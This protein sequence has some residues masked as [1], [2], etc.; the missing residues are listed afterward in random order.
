MAKKD[1]SKELQLLYFP[2]AKEPALVKVP[3]MS[4]L[5]VDGQGDPNTSKDYMNAIGALYSVAYT[6]KFTLKKSA[7]GKDFTVMPLESLWWADDP[8]D[9]PNGEKRKW[10]WTAMIMVPK[11]V[12]KRVVNDTIAQLKK[13][14]KDKELPGLP[15]L[16]LEEF[17]EGLSAQIMHIGPY[18]EERPN[19]EKLHKHIVESGHKIV[20]K[21][22]EIYL[23]DPRRTKPEKLKTVIRQP[24]K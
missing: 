2:S 16:R 15:K 1:L 13:K 23:G 8:K 14:G 12:T 19:I 3:K 22:H 6:A 11:H 24:M 4:F 21:H 5:M 17:D 18:S 7:K 20:G 9:F 10:H